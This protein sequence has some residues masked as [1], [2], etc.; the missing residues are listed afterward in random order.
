MVCL[1]TDFLIEL[2]RHQPAAVS[3]MQELANKDELVHTTVVNVAEY[4]A[5]AF[6]SRNKNAVEMAREYIKGFSTLLLDQESALIWGELYNRLRTDAIGDRDLFI[7]SIA[8][9][10]KQ[11][12]IT[13]NVKHFERVPGLTVESW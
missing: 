10:N 3:R 9:A 6:K 4:Y 13:R 7:A 5:G 2:D 12:L 1:D 8:L 11:T